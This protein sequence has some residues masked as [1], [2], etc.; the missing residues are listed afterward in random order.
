MSEIEDYTN[1]NEFTITFVGFCTDICVVSNVLMTK[2]L[3]YNEAD[4]YVDSSCCAGVTP[5]KHDAALEVMKSCQIN[6]I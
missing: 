2:A 6:V 3:F 4:I 1:G 5:E